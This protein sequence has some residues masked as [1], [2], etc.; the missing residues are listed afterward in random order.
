MYDRVALRSATQGSDVAMRLDGYLVRR[1]DF[2]EVFRL[3]LLRITISSISS[4]L[5]GLVRRWCTGAAGSVS[6]RSD[7]TVAA[8]SGV[9]RP[10]HQTVLTVLL[11]RS[12]PS[13]SLSTHQAC[14]HAC[15]RKAPTHQT[16]DTLPLD[17]LTRVCDSA[18]RASRG[19]SGSAPCRPY[20]GGPFTFD[21]GCQ[22]SRI[23]RRKGRRCMEVVIAYSD[24]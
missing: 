12:M 22:P 24:D 20:P 1:L 23:C 15:L 4:C 6:G 18:S 9:A 2:V 14:P 17:H 11:D 10:R 16:R 8:A 5:V 19:V 7:A 13:D 21:K 3:M